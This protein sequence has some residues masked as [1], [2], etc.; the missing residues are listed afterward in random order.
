M[1]EAKGLEFDDVLLY[2]FF[3]D[4]EAGELWRVVSNYERKDIEAYFSEPAASLTGIQRYDWDELET[5]IRPLGFN[6]D[7]HK[8]LETVSATWYLVFLASPPFLTQFVFISFNLITT[9]KGV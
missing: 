5:Q 1:Q 2:N 6:K 9:Y 7:R 3:T 8:I 4:S